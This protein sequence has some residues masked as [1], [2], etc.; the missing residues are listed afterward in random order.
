MSERGIFFKRGKNNHGS[1]NRCSRGSEFPRDS[2][3]YYEGTHIGMGKHLTRRGRQFWVPGR[4]RNSGYIRSN[5]LIPLIEK[6]IGKPYEEFTKAF[7]AKIKRLREQHKNV[8][9]ADVEDYFKN[10]HNRYRYRGAMYYLD[11]EGIIRSEEETPTNMFT[12][13]QLRYNRD[14]EIPQYGKVCKDY[15]SIGYNYYGC[16]DYSLE[17]YNP[18]FMGNFYCNVDGKILLLPVYHVPVLK[19]YDIK[20]FRGWTHSR[21]LKSGTPENRVYLEECSK[22]VTPTIAIKRNEVNHLFEHSYIGKVH[23]TKKDDLLKNIKEWE[24][25]RD[26]ATTKKDRKYLKLQLK[27]LISKY[28][29]TPDFIEKE[30]GYGRLYPMVKREDYEKVLNDLACSE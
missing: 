19:V 2:M 10:V 3:D 25:L 5:V 6:Y 16:Q 21:F 29:S 1:H 15:R 4:W 24:T 18:V 11:E 28:K 12:N 23:N 26:V 14:Q 13:A 20:K 7:Y 30:A 22:W 8:G 9:I 27:V 17:D